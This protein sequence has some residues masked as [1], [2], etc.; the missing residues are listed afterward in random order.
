MLCFSV[1]CCHL[2]PIIVCGEPIGA[3]VKTGGLT[4]TARRRSR[5]SEGS[6]PRTEEYAVELASLLDLSGPMN[7]LSVPADSRF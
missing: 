6:I 4:C 5:L 2:W 7:V 3:H 1:I